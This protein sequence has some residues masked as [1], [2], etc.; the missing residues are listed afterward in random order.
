MEKIKFGSSGKELD[1]VVCGILADTEKVI[2]KFLP[3]ADSLDSLNTL[4]L[5]SEE[6]TK[7]TLLSDGGE[8]LAIYNGYTKLQSIGKELDAVIGYT[9][10]ADQ[11]PVIGALVTAVLYK[12]DQTE[13]RLASL[14]KQLTDTQMALCEIYE[15]REV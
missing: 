4:L 12:P 5:D 8:T 7:L 3:G 2:L 14:E 15:G 1:L 10:D 9:Q 6:T 13:Q 11:A